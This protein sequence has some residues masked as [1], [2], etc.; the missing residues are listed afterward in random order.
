MITL[1]VGWVSPEASI[2][3]C[4]VLLPVRLVPRYGQHDTRRQ[5]SLPI[6]LRG[7]LPVKSTGSR[8]READAEFDR[9][10]P[11]VEQR[12]RRATFR[13]QKHFSNFTPTERG[14]SSQ[15]R[16]KMICV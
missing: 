6:I 5:L 1:P 12:I 11:N 15:E 14:K 13:H 10:S 9:G 4:T 2:G 8:F 3:Y 7:L 16:P